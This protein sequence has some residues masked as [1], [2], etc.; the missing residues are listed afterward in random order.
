[1]KYYVYLDSDDNAVV[2]SA[3]TI[4]TYDPGFWGRNGHLVSTVWS[5]ESTD[6]NSILSLLETFE[7][8]KTVPKIVREVCQSIGFDLDAYMAARKASLKKN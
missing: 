5:V 8:R 3:D 2:R 6:M 1:M 7:R 4:D